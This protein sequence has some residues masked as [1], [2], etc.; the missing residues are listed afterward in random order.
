MP[1]IIVGIAGAVAGVFGY[2][3]V[4]GKAAKQG[5]SMFSTWDMVKVGAGAVGAYYAVKTFK[6]V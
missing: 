1:F 3:M 6:A 4:T 5:G 2:E